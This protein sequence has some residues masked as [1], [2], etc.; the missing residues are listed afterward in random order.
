MKGYTD[1]KG[2]FRPIGKKK[3]FNRTNIKKVPTTSGVYLFFSKTGKPIYV[4]V[5]KKAK[6]ANLRHR[7]ESYNEKDS[8]SAHPTKKQ[9]RKNIKKFSYEVVPIS[10]AR[11]IEKINKGNMQF[12]RD[13]NIGTWK[14]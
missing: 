7:L 11:R 3:D 9:L 14:R 1:S 13:H 12:N 4:G 10:E 6:Y 8:F 5:S 2:R